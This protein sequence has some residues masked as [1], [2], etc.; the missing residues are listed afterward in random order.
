M[1][2]IVIKGKDIRREFIILLICFIMAMLVNTAAII[3]YDRPW[4]ELYSQIGYVV[5]MSICIYMILAV[6]RAIVY[7]ILSLLGRK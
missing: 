6:I 5:F 4:S 2:D 7:G 3:T 1:K